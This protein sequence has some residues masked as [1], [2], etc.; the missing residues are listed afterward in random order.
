MAQHS[1]LYFSKLT[2]SSSDDTKNSGELGMFMP[3]VPSDDSSVKEWTCDW[4]SLCPGKTDTL[5]VNQGFNVHLKCHVR[6]RKQAPQI[7]GWVFHSIAFFQFCLTLGIHPGYSE[8]LLSYYFRNTDNF[9][10]LQYDFSDS[11]LHEFNKKCLKSSH[12]AIYFSVYY[13][14]STLYVRFIWRFVILKSKKGEI[15]TEFASS[16]PEIILWRY[17]IF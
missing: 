8:M 14:L 9:W 1:L 16:S 5:I 10:W 13:L 3:A 7:K 12:V 15:K 11:E 6:K 17:C 2:L 4:I